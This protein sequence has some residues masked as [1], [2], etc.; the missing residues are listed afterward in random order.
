MTRQSNLNMHNQYKTWADRQAAGDDVLLDTPD[1]VTGFSA[2]QTGA[3]TMD[4][5]WT[6]PVTNAGELFQI[7]RAVVSGTP[8][9]NDV[10]NA[11]ACTF[12]DVGELVG[13]VAHGWVDGDTV[14]FDTVVS[15]TGLSA[16]TRYYVVNANDDDFQIEATLGGG[17]L[18]LVPNGTGTV[19]HPTCTFDDTGDLVNIVGHGYAANTRVMFSGIVSTTGLVE[20]A[21]YY[22]KAPTTDS[23]Q[24]SLTPAGAA[25]ALTTNGY[26][27]LYIPAIGAY[28]VVDTVEADDEAWSDT[29]L[30]TAT[31]YSYRGSVSRKLFEPA[32]GR[33][34]A[35][36]Q[37]A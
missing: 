13:A 18:S 32:A 33:P 22:V 21:S 26:G 31:E 30:T 9:D 34:V 20:A 16:D 29:G 10:G 5:A 6:N 8:G 17:A 27:I 35:Y 36:D 23:F 14:I 37:T 1:P 25:V 19:Y 24:V 11:V 12:T 15:T 3:T 28:S 2:T 4:L 7:E